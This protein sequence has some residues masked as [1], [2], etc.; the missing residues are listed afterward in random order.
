VAEVESPQEGGPIKSELKRHW[1]PT[2]GAFQGLLAWLDEGLDSGG[3]TYLDTRRRLVWYFARK[4]CLNPDELA[5]ET[6]NRVAR[7][8]Q[9]EGTIADAPARYCYIVAKFVLLEYFRQPEQRLSGPAS[10]GDAAE[11]VFSRTPDGDNENREASFDCLEQ[12][13]RGLPTAE[14]DLILDYYQGEERTKIENRRALAARL[15]VTPNALSIRACRIRDRLETC[16]SACRDRREPDTF[17]RHLS[18]QE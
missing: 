8:L 14:R 7:R 13:L 2:R 5:D 6:L 4:R 9:E 15:A 16:V 11:S 1:L 3:E 17:F 10:R 12:C 18:H